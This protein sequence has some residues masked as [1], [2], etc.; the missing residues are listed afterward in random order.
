MVAQ[1]CDEST[2][3]VTTS[4]IT[5]SLGL[6]C[7]RA[8]QRVR[9]EKKTREIEQPRS[10]QNRRRAHNVRVDD[11]KTKTAAESSLARACL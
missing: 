6:Q 9:H 1:A 3:E 10:E 5:A 2:A 7:H 4:L 8:V 11:S